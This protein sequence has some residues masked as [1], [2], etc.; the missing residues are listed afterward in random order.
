[1]KTWMLAALAAAAFG[2]TGPAAAQ[3]AFKD[4]K[5]AIEYRQGAMHVMGNHFGR[6]G[7]MVN[8][9]VPFDAKVVQAN[10]DVVAL[11]VKLPWAGFD[12]AGSD[13]GETDAKP[14]I[15]AQPQ[16]F[17]DGIAKA[18]DAGEKLAAAAK[19]GDQAQ[20]K[21]AFGAMAQTCKGC[22]DTFRKE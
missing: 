5:D 18:M 13:K 1:M 22:H 9:K 6:I 8:N 20:V 17:K 4:A 12:V 14:E 21:V 16:K 2:A 7:A 10:A 19:T 15:W 11:M 3:S